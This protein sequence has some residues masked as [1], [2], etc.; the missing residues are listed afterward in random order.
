MCM[1]E[2]TL[3][4]AFQLGLQHHQAGRLAE[5]EHV[6]RQILG[7]AAG[8]EETNHHLAILAIQV[9]QLVPAVEILTRLVAQ[10]PAWPAARS[11]LGIALLQIGRGPEAIVHLEAALAAEPDW[12]ATRAN[13]G[14]AYASC[15][16]SAEAAEAFAGVL[17]Q[18]PEHVEARFNLGVALG[19]LGREAEAREAFLEALR[20]QPGMALGEMNLGMACHSLGL[21][22][23]AIGA[24]RRALALQPDLSWASVHLAHVLA[25]RGQLEEA[26]EVCG[27]ALHH[28]PRHAVLHNNLGNLLSDLGLLDE[29]LASY[30]RALE[31]D[32][33]LAVAHSNML[34]HLQYLP[35]PDP[36]AILEAHRQWNQRY[37]ACNPPQAEVRRPVAQG[38]G[39]RLRIGYLSPDL[40]NHPVGRLLLPLLEH[41]DPQQVEVFAYACMPNEDAMSER[42][43]QHVAAWRNLA[44][45]DDAAAAALIAKDEIDILVDLAGHTAGHRLLVMARRP[46]PIQVT[47]LGY[48]DTTGLDAIDFRLTDSL[49]DPPGMTESLHSEELLRL[50]PCAWCSPPLSDI[51]P[52]PR[53]DGPITFGCFN[54]ASKVNEPLLRLWASIL[55]AVP[56]S[57]LLLKAPGW[58]GAGARQRIHGLFRAAG[59][60][61][62]RIELRGRVESFDEHLALHQ[63]MDIALDTFPYHG[64]TMTLE[65]LWMGI[66]VVTLAGSR[67]VS[68]VGVSLL[69]NVGHPELIAQTAEEYVALAVGLAADHPRLGELRAGLRGQLLASPLMH[70]GG[71][72]RRMETAFRTMVETV[73]N[74]PEGL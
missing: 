47:Y 20:V 54:I 10:R 45:L 69:S 44:A 42:L 39:R 52:I 40:R 59:I 53:A 72:A 37:A 3:D 56:G 18:A 8:H 28:E 30:R 14:L 33:G 73:G 32:P 34:L 9:G 71:L 23:E 6:Y 62:E 25:G 11:N 36:Q 24:L 41:H 66:P 21:D 26:L 4:A 15:Q 29:A 13:L 68:R 31:H 16:R 64:T 38:A 12:F 61:P 70:G 2:V 19:Q 74:R 48:P 60:A 49:A 7:V 57:R 17:R 58:G 63:R 46:A 67:H 65:A 27:A 50:D 43:R 22:D 51:P 35:D 55:A 5:A 1:A